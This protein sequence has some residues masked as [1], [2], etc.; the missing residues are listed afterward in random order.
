MYF[1]EIEIPEPLEVDPF[2]YRAAST[3]WNSCIG[4][5]GD[6]H[7]YVFG[8]LKA[9]VTLV[10]DVIS[11]KKFGDRDTVVW[12][13]LYSVRHGIELGLKQLHDLLSDA[14]IL[15]KIFVRNHSLDEF[16]LSFT[17][18]R[19]GDSELDYLFSK[20]KIFVDSISKL[21]GCLLYTSP[22]PRDAT[23]SRMPSSA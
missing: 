17:N 9:S 4:I 11:N 23:L 12:P 22:S 20:L 19:I 14:G 6:E 21:D 15:N 10:N 13:A 3:D 8:F 7:S 18:N 5:Q 16:M 1:K 2:R